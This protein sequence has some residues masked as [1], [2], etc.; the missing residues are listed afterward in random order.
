MKSG[1]DTEPPGSGPS[2]I[3]AAF[4][5]HRQPRWSQSSKISAPRKE[6]A[7]G[8]FDVPVSGILDSLL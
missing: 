2:G 4:R 7:S 1:L 6:I 3:V 5:P 8:L